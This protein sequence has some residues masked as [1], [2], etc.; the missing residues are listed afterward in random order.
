[1]TTVC[2]T[3]HRPKQL[4]GTYDLVNPK[5]SLLIEKLT[6]TLEKL[7][8]DEGVDT[9]ISGGALGGDQLA[10]ICVNALKKKYPHI[11][12]ILAAPYRDQAKGWEEQLEKAKREGWGKAIQD[13]EKTLLRY[14]RILE[15]AD[16]VVYV[17]ELPAYLPRGM[18]PEQTGKH[19]NAKLQI[20]NVYMVDHAD[21]VIA[22]FDGSKG[23]TYNCVK[24][25]R[26]KGKRLIVL[27]P[28]QNFERTEG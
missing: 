28:K 16:E 9:F 18:K 21:I 23:G 13:L 22:I 10:F 7:I 5:A 20:R 8:E 19:S 2:F 11:R 12:N 25:A 1:M 27:D 17:D 15:L 24:T 3:A 6:E 14:A 26:A 4:F